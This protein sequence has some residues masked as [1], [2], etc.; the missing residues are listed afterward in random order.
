[1]SEEASDR[2]AAHDAGISELLKQRG[3]ERLIGSSD[4]NLIRT[5]A[6]IAGSKFGGGLSGLFLGIKGDAA[7]GGREVKLQCFPIFRTQGTILIEAFGLVG[8]GM[9]QGGDSIGDLIEHAADNATDVNG[10]NEEDIEVGAA[11]AAA[12]GF[13]SGGLLVPEFELIHAV[14]V[15][16]LKSCEGLP[17]ISF[18]PGAF[19]PESPMDGFEIAVFGG[20]LAVLAAERGAECCPRTDGI[21]IGGVWQGGGE[22]RMRQGE[23]SLPP[24]EQLG[25]V[26][27]EGF[28]CLVEQ[29]GKG[30]EGQDSRGLKPGKACR[31]AMCEQFEEAAGSTCTGNDHGDGGEVE[32]R[33]RG[34][35]LDEVVGGGSQGW[36][37]APQKMLRDSHRI[38][39]RVGDVPAQRTNTGKVW[40]L[41]IAGFPR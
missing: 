40:L 2:P 10:G 27:S 29:F 7:G 32:I 41:S 31:T 16:L 9:N 11:F 39:C 19:F 15:L 8:I 38:G 26:V 20:Q 18:G 12:Y 24:D 35:A 25:E 17:A 37:V 3:Y 6:V 4:H 5:E 14:M 30:G 1:M 33:T 23:Q 34:V 21:R 13:E 28:S 36:L 22:V